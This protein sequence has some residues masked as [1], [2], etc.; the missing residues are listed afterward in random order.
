MSTCNTNNFQTYRCESCDKRVPKNRPLLNCTV[1]LKARHYKCHGLSKTEAN[2]IIRNIGT[3]HWAC[4]D[5]FP[6]P[7][8]S[9]IDDPPIIHVNKPPTS[10]KGSACHVCSKFCHSNKRYICHWCDNTC[11]KKCSK[12][13][14]GCLSCCDDMT[15][16]NNLDLFELS[17]SHQLKNNRL[18][19]PYDRAALINQIGNTISNEEESSNWSSVSQKLKECQYIDPCQ[20]NAVKCNELMCL[21]H[22]IRSLYK[23]MD[24]LRENQKHYNNFDIICFCETS[25]NPETLPNGMD[26]LILEGFHPPIVQNPLRASNRGG[27][28]AIYINKRLCDEENIT[29]VPI[30]ESVLNED[31]ALECQAVKVEIDLGNGRPKYV[32]YFVNSYR[33]PSGKLETFFDNL[34]TLLS[35]LDRYRNKHVTFVGDLNIDLLKF[36][37]VLNGSLSNKLIDRTSDHGFI[38]MISR[39]TR[40]TEHSATLIDHVFTNS[41]HDVVKSGVITYD[42]SDHLGTFVV[43]SLD[44]NT[45]TVQDV[46]FR[47]EYHKFNDENMGKFRSLI[48]EQD[49][50]PIV[51]ELNPQVKYDI[52]LDTY[53]RLYNSAFPLTEPSRKSQRANP[54]PWILP[55]LETACERKNSLY[56]EFTKNPSNENK[57]SYDEMKKFVTTQIRKAKNKY[58]R[59]YFEQYNSDS[60][61]Q[62]QMLNSLTN[63]NKKKRTI[64]KLRSPDGT[65]ISPQAT[66]TIFNDYFTTIAE[67]LKTKTQDGQKNSTN[68]TE[69]LRNRISHSMYVSPT[70]PTEISNHI[71]SLKNKTT[72]DTKVN[73]LKTA[74]AIPIFNKILSEVVN[75]SFEHGV[76]PTQLK[77]AKVIPVYKNG[78]KTQ[79]SNYRP[80]SLLSVFSKIFEKAMHKRVYEFLQRNESLCENQFGFRKS[81]SCEHALLVAQNELLKSLGKN[82]I[83]LLLFIDFSKAFDMVNHDILLRKLEHYGIRGIANKWFESYLKGREQYVSVNSTSSSRKNLQYSV[84]QGSILGPLLFIIYINDLPNISELAKYILYAD[85]A[86]IIITGDTIGQVCADYYDVTKL[87][88]RWVQDNELLLNVKKTNYMI[89]TRKR[90][91]D[92]NAIS[93]KLGNASIER[94]HV[95][96]FLGVLIDDKLKW[97][98]HIL[99]VRHKMSRYI[100]T[101][102]KIKHMLP[103]KCRL[104]TFNSLVMS[105]LNYCSLVW[106]ATNKSKIDRIF[107][108][109]KKAVRAIMNGPVNYYYD[110]GKIPTHTKPTFTEHKIPTVHNV[111]A[112]NMLN[113]AHKL[114]ISDLLPHSVNCIISKQ[115][116]CYVN[117]MECTSSWYRE[118]SQVPF[119][120][121]T[122]F[123]APLLQNKFEDQV[124]ELMKSSKCSTSLTSYKNSVKSLTQKIQGQGSAE[125]WENDNFILYTS[126]GLRRSDRNTG[127]PAVN[128]KVE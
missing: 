101:I 96:K 113:F 76:F 69:N 44:G 46:N 111:I 84:P 22:N 43:Y 97:D 31:K 18:F 1:C 94:T 71:L 115:S 51:T 45:G 54:K 56:F 25:C 65:Q 68:F 122:Q 34:N 116:P 80:I 114:H 24:H 57:N 118:Y 11:H 72:G 58:Y 98:H 120:T 60:R 12:D 107:S 23:Y 66:A 29:N 104:L 40:I 126:L 61:K 48:Q 35:S 21:S 70:C 109:Q 9:Y 36:G 27:G 38:Q 10:N 87:L 4:N 67:K 73:A 64:I 53:S 52:F 17:P 6:L 93:L 86:N 50:E 13:T 121:S 89:F 125:N 108:M 3:Y 62:W 112:N 55:W 127:K 81:R 33:S 100:G 19:D 82:K 75:S 63:R 74:S 83:S 37:D 119:N 91:I 30:L 110:E 78:S 77:L 42:M 117:N 47:E 88:L 28:L 32:H 92:K 85:D 49:W 14:L 102:H 79:V 26:D 124:V 106:G 20:L 105:H 95:A 7:T 99:A 103:M 123:K 90:S 16:G 15:P 128:Y 59:R 5:C 8:L 2:E 41:V 39:P